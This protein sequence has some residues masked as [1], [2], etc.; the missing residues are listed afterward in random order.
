MKVFSFKYR[1]I[2][3][4]VLEDEDEDSYTYRINGKELVIKCPKISKISNLC[5]ATQCSKY[6]QDYVLGLP[7]V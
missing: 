5:Y 7:I 2:K 1:Q 6:H 4:I 3:E